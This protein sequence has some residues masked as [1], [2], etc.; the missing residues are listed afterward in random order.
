M[1]DLPGLVVDV[2]AR[3][4]KLERGLNQANRMQRR[5]STQM[6]RRADQLADRMETSYGRA[7]L[8]VE[9][10]FKRLGPT[11]LASVSTA[12]I[13]ATVNRLADVTRGVAE[14]GDAAAIA[15]VSVERFQELKFVADQNRVGVNA[16]TD[17][18]KELSLRAD[19]FVTTGAGPAAEAFAR[20][21]FDAADLARRLEDPSELFLEIVGRLEDLDSAAQIRIADEVFG[22][23][24][25]EQFVQLLGRGETAL[26]ATMDRARATGQVLDADVIAKAQELDA[27]FTAL[28]TRVGN[29]FKGAIV[30]AV[31]F[32]SAL[33]TVENEANRLFQTLDN[34]QSL[35]PDANTDDLQDM[36]DDANDLSIEYQ[37]LKQSVREAGYALSDAAQA[38][39]NDA[40][41]EA[42]RDIQEMSDALS[43]AL[44]LFEDGQTS[45]ED[46]EA[47][48]KRLADQAA[49]TLSEVEQIDGLTFDNAVSAVDVLS[50]ALQTAV[51]MAKELREV[52]AEET[53]A[54]LGSGG[55]RRRGGPRRDDTV[56]VL[57]PDANTPR[58]R[59]APNDPDFGQP[60]I[61]TGGSG[62]GG[63][64]ARTRPEQSDFDREIAS[65]AE[66]TQALQQEALA[67]AALSGERIKQG[68]ALDYARTRAD[69]MTAAMKSGLQDTPALRQQI[70]DLATSYVD[71]ATGADQAAERLNE[72]QEASRNGAQSIAS[73]FSQMAT[74]AISAT[75]A[76]KQL[77]LQIIQL[78]IQKRI[79]QAAEGASGLFGNFLAVVGGGFSD[80][81]YTGPGGKHEPAGVVH[82]GEYVM[83]KA[84]TSAIGVGNLEALHQSA[85]RGYA[86]GGFVGGA[87]MAI[88]SNRP[89]PPAPSVSISAPVTVS[90]SAGT[91]AQN[92]DLAKQ[93]ARE[94]EGTMRGAVADELIR[95][96][97]PG[98]LLNTGR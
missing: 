68:D 23:T 39:G 69:L 55:P 43:G 42:Q 93:I 58:P 7:G 87:A 72:I 65:I 82:R 80:G 4:N 45:A 30:G 81:G 17:G 33:T 38:A 26:R 34:S 73:V 67:I 66:E 64:G 3:I 62:G 8:S 98:A 47:Q 40:Y 79:M 94:M 78:T 6:Q 51:T 70:D 53:G 5:A 24:G 97:R 50:T 77:I 92:L 9:R 63:G 19:E 91:E 61:E 84:A 18:L 96:M 95:Q 36:V 59:A 48:I 28:K 86:D 14:I 13:G 75:D 74:G 44:L 12:A 89:E 56:E 31:D 25:G 49:T 20:L 22:G 54:T 15:G 1:S 37:K 21:N 52:V 88:R 10:V 2:E 27:R 41:L 11:L 57:T 32:A 83:S 60:P 76:V 85:K 71:A 35:V 46:F 16:L 90:G 29:F